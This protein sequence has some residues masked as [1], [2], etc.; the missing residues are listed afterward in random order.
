MNQDLWDS[1]PSDIQSI[2]YYATEHMSEYCFIKRF[3]GQSKDIQNWEHILTLD[4]ETI[5][6]LYLSELEEWYRLATLDARN[7][8]GIKILLEYQLE[9]EEMNWTHRAYRLDTV[10][11]KAL[12]ERVKQL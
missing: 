4:D 7:A 9:L 8:Q 1:L 2:V 6:Q 10:P 12:L 5:Q 11:M 3:N